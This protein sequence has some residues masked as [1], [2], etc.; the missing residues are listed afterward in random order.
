MAKVYP[1]HTITPEQ[2]EPGHR[3]VYHDHDDCPDGKRI[4]PQNRRSGTDNR[5]RCDACI[6]LG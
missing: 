6:A 5:P 4:E 2:G 3:N 1:Y